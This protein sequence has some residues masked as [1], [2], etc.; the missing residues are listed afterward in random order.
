[1]EIIITEK[2]GLYEENPKG[3]NTLNDLRSQLPECPLEYQIP[4]I[5][6]SHTALVIEIHTADIDW[7]EKMLPWTLAGPHQQHRH[8]DERRASLRRLR[9]RRPQ[10]TYQGRSQEV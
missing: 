9:G 8:C 2:T 1:M 10:G 4:H 7:Q 6:G 5:P 3:D